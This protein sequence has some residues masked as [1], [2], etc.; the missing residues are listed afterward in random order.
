M[1]RQNK[2]I[3]L[4]VGPA[5]EISCSCIYKYT[6]KRSAFLIPSLLNKVLLFSL[7]NSYKQKICN[8]FFVSERNLLY[9]F[10]L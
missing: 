8:H 2:M 7:I 6:I 9:Y 4:R 5:V 3:N 10:T 1:M